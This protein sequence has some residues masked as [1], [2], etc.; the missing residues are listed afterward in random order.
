MKNLKRN[1]LALAALVAFAGTGCKDKN[2]DITLP[3]INGYPNSDAVASANL[4][5]YFPLDGTGNEAKTGTAPTASVNATY[6]AGVKGQSVSLNSGYLYYASPLGPLASGQGFS[7]SAWVQV[8]NNQVDGQAPPVANF[9]YSYF[10]SA[11]PGKLFGNLTGLVETGAYKPTSDTMRVKSIY[12]DQA[13]GTQDNVNGFDNADIGVKWN[14]SKKA[15]TNQ[16]AHIVTTYNPAGGTPAENVFQIYVDSVIVGNTDFA[17]RG[18]NSF[19]YTPGEIII[20]GWYNNIPGKEINADNFTQPFKGK[21]DEIRLY[22]KLLTRDEI[23]ALYNL[24][25]AGR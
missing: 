15:G 25:R 11:I 23:T 19:K 8:A 12:Q 6:T 24:G 16:W 5:A 1:V 20:G 18:T 3:D 21:I 13:G 10:Q 7:L 2:D 9:P 4:V 22:S 14:V 17:K